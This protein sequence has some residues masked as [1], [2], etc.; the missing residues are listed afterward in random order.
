M[1]LYI[2]NPLCDITCSAETSNSIP[3]IS[4]YQNN[5]LLLSLFIFNIILMMVICIIYNKVN[6]LDSKYNYKYNKVRAYVESD[7]D[8]PINH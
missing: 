7:T 3:F 6:K 4:P 5:L 1:Y 8:Q 2:D